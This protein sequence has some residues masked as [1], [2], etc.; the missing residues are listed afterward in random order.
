MMLMPQ[1]ADASAAHAGSFPAQSET[2]SPAKVPLWLKLAMSAFVAVLVPVYWVHYGPANFLYFCDMALLLTLAG[3]WLEKPLLVSMPAV[4][5]LMP[6]V[7]WIA[8]LLATLAGFKLVGL[9]DYMVDASLPLYLRAL[10]LFHGWLPLLLVWGVWRLGYDRRAL[11]GWTA[12]AWA[13]MLVSYFFIPGPSP[14]TSTIAA[15][16]NYVF[17]P[18]ATAPQTW[19]PG[20]A[21]LMLLMS[22]LPVVMFAPV[23]FLLVRFGKPAPSR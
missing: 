14:E 13:S 10:S 9:T 3:L 5:I 2:L 12:V 11:A 21:W 22:A 23:H 7:L 4:G 8:D 6:Q 17:G 18:S 16:V 1:I 15:N 20:W 19:M